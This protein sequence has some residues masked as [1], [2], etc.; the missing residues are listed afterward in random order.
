MT[1][2]RA[3]NRFYWSIEQR[4]VPG[5]RPTQ[6]AYYETLLRV[7]RPDDEWLDLGCGHQVFG[8]WMTREQAKAISSC[9]RIYGIDLDWQGLRAHTGIANKIYGDLGRLPVRTS[10]VD[11]VTANMVIEHLSDPDAVLREIG[12]VLRPGGRFVFHT[13]NYNSP[14]VRL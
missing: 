8:G 11:V 5:L 12:R 1:V 14:V 2:R 3:L 4:F 13:P 9:R 10:S 6:Y 7:L